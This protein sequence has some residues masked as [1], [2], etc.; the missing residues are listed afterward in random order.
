MRSLQSW[1]QAV[2]C[3][4]RAV[5]RTAGHRATRLG[6][7]HLVGAAL[8][9]LLLTLAVSGTVSAHG[10]PANT[11]ERAAATRTAHWRLEE[12]A[13]TTTAP[14]A[15]WTT[16]LGRAP[17]DPATALSRAPLAPAATQPAIDGRPVLRVLEMTATAYGPSWAA[18]YP[19]GPVDYYGQPLKSGMVAVDPSVIPLGSTVYVSGYQDASLPPGGF[20]GQA[21]DTGDAIIGMRIDIFMNQG[22]ASVSQF[23]VQPVTVYVL[24]PAHHTPSRA[25]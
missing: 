14:N 12:V 3:Q 9:A 18:N 11:R 6:R 7:W 16:S 17:K 2:T 13:A 25:P 19:Y 4:M 5:L 23:G 20:T 24:G 22:A 15:L 8:P 10:A 1:V 21:L